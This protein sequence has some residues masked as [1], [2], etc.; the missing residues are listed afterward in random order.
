MHKSNVKKKLDQSKY[1]KT[2]NKKRSQIENEK[3][4]DETLNYK[5]GKYLPKDPLDQFQL[6]PQMKIYIYI[7]ILR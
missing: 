3:A 1:I 4:F 6:Q 7:Y 5:V 2:V